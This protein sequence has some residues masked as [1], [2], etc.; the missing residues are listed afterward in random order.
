MASAADVA[1]SITIDPTAAVVVSISTPDADPAT[2]YT[3]TAGT[4]ATFPV[5]VDSATQ[6]YGPP[7]DYVVSMLAGGIEVATAEGQSRTVK[8]D[9]FGLSI[10]PA[11]EA[12]IPYCPGPLP[13]LPTSD[14]TYTLVLTVADGLPVMAWS[15]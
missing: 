7:G 9:R 5:V 10:Q 4:S 8:F 15:D 12:L 1:A 14:S 6:F 13:A 11:Y 2:I 3:D